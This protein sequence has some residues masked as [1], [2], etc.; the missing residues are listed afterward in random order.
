MFTPDPV[1]LPGL[2]ALAL[3]FLAF[4][5][6]LLIARRQ[7]SVTGREVGAR[8]S[9]ASTLGILIQGFGIFI[10]GFGPQRIGLDPL[11]AAALGEAVTVAL[12]MAGAVALFAWATRTMGRNWSIV[13]RT[14]AD[15]ALVQDGPFALVRH[16]I[17]VAMAL[18]MV[19][20]AIATGHSRQ[21]LLAAPVFAIG[22]AIRVRIEERLL[23]VMFGDAYDAYAKRVP[24]YVPGLF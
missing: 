6:A 15:H 24:P 4:A 11:S 18:I 22:T 12:L 3:G 9:S 21:L 19:A 5:V 14:R 16:P 8:R 10:A 17:Y 13:A 20:L 7:G 2:A 1:G 23:R